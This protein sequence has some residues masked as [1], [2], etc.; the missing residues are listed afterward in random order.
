M[1]F[2]VLI[3]IMLFV[4][5]KQLLKKCDLKLYIHKIRLFKCLA[6]TQKYMIIT[7]RYTF[8][9][10]YVSFILC[11]LMDYQICILWDVAY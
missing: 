6:V 8:I 3:G 7:D 4:Y 10:V 9:T 2:Y 1:M 5:R 11:F